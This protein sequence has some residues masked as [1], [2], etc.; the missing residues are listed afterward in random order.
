MNSVALERDTEP[1]NLIS[2][3]SELKVLT[4]G[5]EAE[6]LVLDELGR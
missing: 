2:Q 3:T 5:I 4:Q 6:V 1:Y